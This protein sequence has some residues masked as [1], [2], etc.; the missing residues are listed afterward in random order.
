M[1]K[2][3]DDKIVNFAAK[4]RQMSGDELNVQ[5]PAPPEEQKLFEDILKSYQELN[6]SRGRTVKNAKRDIAII[7][8]FAAFTGK[9]PWWCDEV[10]FESWSAN[11]GQVRQLALS[12]QRLYQ[13]AIERFFT[14]V[15]GRTRFNGQIQ[16]ITGCAVRQIVNNDNRVAHRNDRE[17]RREKPAMTFDEVQRF[18]SAVD[19][20]I[21]QAAV[22]HGKDLYPLLRDRAHFFL[23]YSGAHR[24]SE[25]LNLHLESFQPNQEI[26]ELGDFGYTSV[27]RKGSN[28]SGQ[29]HQMVPTTNPAMGEMM[30]WYIDS[31]RPKLALK[32]KDANDDTL[33]LSERGTKMGYSNLHDRFQKALERAG[34]AGRGFT[35]HSLR[36]TCA[37]HEALTLSLEAIRIKLGH[38]HLST[39]QRYLHVPDPYVAAEI[40]GVVHARVAASVTRVA[41]KER[42]DGLREQRDALGI[43]VTDQRQM[44]ATA[45]MP[46]ATL[47]PNPGATRTYKSGRK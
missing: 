1:A 2:A 12:S 30:A 41:K 8:D 44:L 18:F 5:S 16:E 40:E 9:M 47:H 27:M 34:L 46:A 25:T 13:G 36:H 31:V 24:A 11:L 32:L 10:D 23:I 28:G 33:F 45:N 15:D 19:D 4:V 14:Y 20:T 26:P 37:T 21:K 42:S 35:L 22:F 39:T 6:Q 29:K 43:S 38:A 7:Q 17:L 3:K